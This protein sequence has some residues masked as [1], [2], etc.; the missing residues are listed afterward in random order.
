MCRCP[1]LRP[2]QDRRVRPYDVVGSAP[3]MSTTKASHDRINLSGLNHTAWTLAVYASQSGLPQS[4]ARLASRCWPLYGT[5]LV[6]RRIPTKGFRVV[7]YISSS[8]LKLPGA[9]TFLNSPD[10]ISCTKP[11]SVGKLLGLDSTA[12]PPCSQTLFGNTLLETPFPGCSR[13]RVSR[14][15]VPKRSLG[16]RV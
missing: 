9:R 13:N 8:L 4:H 10:V 15:C 12:I 16:T 11:G 6:T 1:A 2:R 5:G 14:R 3:A 7:S